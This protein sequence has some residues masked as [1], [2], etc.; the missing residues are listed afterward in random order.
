MGLE[1]E[2]G[3]KEMINVNHLESKPI[4]LL[5]Y[6]DQMGVTLLSTIKCKRF[7]IKQKNADYS[8]CNKP[9]RPMINTNLN[10]M[11]VLKPGYSLYSSDVLLMYFLSIHRS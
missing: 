9:S 3:K 11:K 6:L 7:V 4:P 10:I 5:W 2:I 8:I 1:K